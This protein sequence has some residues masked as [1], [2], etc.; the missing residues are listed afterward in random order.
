[1]QSEQVDVLIVGAGVSGIGAGCHLTMKCPERSFVI[2]EGRDAIG[3]TWD[4]F[5]YPG[6]RSDSNM[7]TFGYAFRP[8]T[9]DECLASGDA[10]RDYV[11]DTARE[12][13]VD[14]KIRFRHRVLRVDWSSAENRWIADVKRL[15]SD[16]TFRMKAR[17]L[18]TCTGYY[19]YE[20]GHQPEFAGIDDFRGTIAHPQHWPQDLDYTGKKVLIIGSG[21]TAVT[22]V[23]AM[24]ADADHVTMLQRS[25]TY[26]LSLPS[27]DEMAVKLRRYLPEMA[28]Y[29]LT[30]IKSILFGMGLF[31]Y[32]RRRPEK[33]RRFIRKVNKELLG[34][35]IDVDV[36]FKPKYD[37]WDQRL[38]LAKDADFFQV[39]KDGSATVVTDRIDCF[40]ETGVKLA[41]G[42]ELTADVIVPATGLEL[43]FLGGME[44]SR[45]GEPVDPA[46]LITYRGMMFGGLPN[47]VAVVGYTNASWTLKVDITCDYVCRLLEYMAKRGYTRVTP[48][49][50]SRPAETE[51]MFNLNSGY[52]L[53][54]AS[55]VPKQSTEAPWRNRHN[56]IA[57][58]LATRFARFNDGVMTFA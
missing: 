29:R 50:D 4:L 44:M 36:H 40:T 20:H 54:A 55:R 34:P 37:P 45:D 41:S 58:W 21:A 16:E 27:T 23:P 42:Q 52:L 7:F 3:G 24:A 10:I 28:V 53:R 11:Q 15:D 30:R 33:M 48:R 2:L 13:G 38:C 19:N 25:P 35:D 46:T 8:W 57:D 39:L 26:V 22:L 5:R 32:S 1:M 49:L 43:Q 6:I 47:F 14:K 31:I 18:L 17:F 9:A 51:P 56:Y 12:Y